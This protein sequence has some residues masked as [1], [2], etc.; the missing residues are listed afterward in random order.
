MDAIHGANAL[1]LSTFGRILN[2]STS[3][4]QTPSI[5]L[6]KEYLEY[7]EHAYPSN[8]TYK[9]QPGQLIPKRQL[10]ARYKKIRQLFPDPLTSFAGISCSK[11]FFVFSASLYP[12]CTRTLGIDIN[13][14]DVQFCQKIK[15]YL[16]NTRSEFATMRLHELAERIDEFGGPFQTVILL[17]SYQY[18]YFGSEYFPQCYLDHDL[19]FKNLSKICSERLIFSNRVNIEDVQVNPS[20]L[21]ARDYHAEYTE[22]KIIKAASNY[23]V[24]QHEGYIGRYPLWAL[25]RVNIKRCGV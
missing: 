25:D 19:I 24:V 13:P 23:F 3:T 1:F 2:L 16:G 7:A 17:N 10:A 22:E 15:E 18:L 8:H 4:K 14:Y 21:N 11:G 9:I 5:T 6:P 12:S 20:L